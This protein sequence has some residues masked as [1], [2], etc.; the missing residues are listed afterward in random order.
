MADELNELSIA[1][2]AG[3]AAVEMIDDCLSQVWENIRDR[4]T[5]AEKVRTVTLKIRI[6]PDEERDVGKVELSCT[7][8]LAPDKPITTRVDIGH[9]GG[10]TIAV[11]HPRQTD[12]GEF[13]DPDKVRHIGGKE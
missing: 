4:N 11:E 13:I 3:G 7:P 6:K 1:N 10:R 8:T 9:E 2:I 12:I 5:E